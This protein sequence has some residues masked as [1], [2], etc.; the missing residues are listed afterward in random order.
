MYLPRKDIRLVRYLAENGG[1]VPSRISDIS[2]DLRISPSTIDSILKRLQERGIIRRD[3]WH[4][5]LAVPPE[6]AERMLRERRGG[7]IKR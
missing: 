1:K 7:P 5:Y 4:I 2:R 6:E 3:F